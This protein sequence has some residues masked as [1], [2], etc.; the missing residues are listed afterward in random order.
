MNFIVTV[1]TTGGQLEYV[2][3]AM[4]TK[5]MNKRL[6]LEEEEKAYWDE[7][8]KVDNAVADWKGV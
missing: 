2:A 4:W 5:W 8:R 7:A 1:E 6:E 3:R